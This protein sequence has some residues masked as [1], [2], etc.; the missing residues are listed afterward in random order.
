MVVG[1]LAGATFVLYLPPA[2]TAQVNAAHVGSQ[3]W[4]VGLAQRQGDSWVAEAAFSASGTG[5]GAAF[6]PSD[7]VNRR[8]GELR[9]R[10]IDCDQAEFT[11]SSEGEDSAGFGSGGYSLQRLAPNPAGASCQ[12]QGFS[13]QAAS[14]DYIQGTWYGGEGRSGEG[15]LID[16]LSENQA[17]IAFFTHRPSAN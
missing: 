3:Y 8:W 4:I 12:Q 2:E 9:L 15:L 16:R 10:F 14:A 7:L 1:G 11:W 13:A 5:F 6:R 17:L